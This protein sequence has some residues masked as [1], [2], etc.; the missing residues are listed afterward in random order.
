MKS[1]AISNLWERLKRQVSLKRRQPD[2]RGPQ[3]F[4]PPLS[5]WVPIKDPFPHLHSK[6]SISGAT[7]SIVFD[8]L[9]RPPPD[10]EHN[11][12]L[13]ISRLP[14][15][16]V[17]E[18]F[19]LICESS[20]TEYSWIACTHVCA[21]W[22]QIA[23]NTPL[24]WAHVVFESHAWVSTCLERSKS[25]PLIVTADI[26]LAV[27][28]TLVCD[29]LKM[30]ERIVRIHLRLY[31]PGQL[32][33]D[34]LLGP[35]PRLTDLSVENYTWVASNIPV[36]PDAP[37]FPAL[38]SLLMCTN[39]PYLPPL[40]SQLVS[41]EIYF[42]GWQPIPWDSLALALGQLHQLHT[43]KLSGFS[44]PPSSPSQ[45]ISFPVLRDLHL[46]GSPEH[47]TQ[48]IETLES[49]KLRR[50]NLHLSNFDNL[51]VLFRTFSVRMP[52]PPKCMMMDHGDGCSAGGNDLLLLT[53]SAAY[54]QSASISFIYANFGPWPGDVAIDV[55][56]SW[57]VPT[58]RSDL[59]LA[60]IFVA[61]PEFAWLEHIEYLWIRDWCTIPAAL[62]Q[63]FLGRLAGLQTLAAIGSPPAGLFWALVRHLESTSVPMSGEG[64][65]ATGGGSGTLLP[66]MHTIRMLNLN[67]DAGNWLP[68][69]Q[70]SN[71][72]GLPTNPYFDLDNTR[73]LELLICYLELR[74]A[75]LARL[76]MRECFGYTGAEVKLLRRLVGSMLWD[77]WGMDEGVYQANGD[78]VGA[79]TINHTLIARQKG[80]E[81]LNLSEA[82]RWHEDSTLYLEVRPST[83]IS[84]RLYGSYADYEVE[85]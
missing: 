22:R 34:L 20:F 41:L 10:P 29:V 21:S 76:V 9:P 3:P 80:Y 23:L 73:F 82:D 61:L 56:L 32:I 71:P 1:V 77:G 28:E 7:P 51:P 66:A 19:L 85:E 35:F 72:A 49:P 26:R 63:L 53:P 27:V 84:D 2:P 65:V 45:P 42:R 54:S 17:V 5:P 70:S 11:A 31:V 83:R 74:A 79:L 44:A 13:K 30:A 24:L 46:S 43:L 78:Y 15:E 69:L 68:Q 48:F 37:S 4:V 81:E 39:V 67:C 8:P 64:E 6:S 38:R 75:P 52:K 47:C 25:S 55:C 60:T 57:I 12:K 36:Q 62:W 14:P 18:I 59:A 40:P 33:L 58:L 50:F 16:I